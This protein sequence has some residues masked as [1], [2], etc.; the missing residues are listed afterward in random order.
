DTAL[1]A[2]EVL[3]GRGRALGRVAEP[4]PNRY[5]SSLTPKIDV[6]DCTSMD[7]NVNG[8]RHSYF[9]LNAYL[10]GDLHELVSRG[11]PASR[12]SRLVRTSVNSR[13]NVFSFLAPPVFVNW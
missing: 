10:V 9:D 2:G 13:S 4:V 6:V 7:A 8:I 3:G 11:T 1:W 5:D 12:R